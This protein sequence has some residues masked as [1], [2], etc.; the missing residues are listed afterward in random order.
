MRKTRTASTSTTSGEG[1][2]Q[3]Q[4][5]WC[6]VTRTRNRA[7][8]TAAALLRAATARRASGCAAGSAPQAI[9]RFLTPQPTR[10]SWNERGFD[11]TY[12]KT[13]RSTLDA[14]GF[15]NT[16]IVASDSSWD[17]ISTDILNDPALASA[18]HAIG[19]HYPG[20][21][22]SKSAEETGKP[23][24]ASEDDSTYD[25][26]IGGECFA[27][28]ISRNYVLGNM[29]RHLF[30][31]CARVGISGWEPSSLFTPLPH[32]TLLFPL[33][34]PQRSTGAFAL[35]SPALLLQGVRIVYQHIYAALP[36]HPA[37][38]RLCTSA[39]LLTPYPPPPPL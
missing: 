13:L 26:A 18:V 33:R 1:A 2:R 28:I 27:R 10:S 8:A 37:S 17:P 5:Q 24:W 31:L 9:S 14:N 36:V 29:V 21:S 25:N 19:T 16:K 7:S 35:A 4:R 3:R 11:A 32:E 12:L 38:W 15:T 34:R 6:G 20:S 23:L 30:S 22:S 39:A